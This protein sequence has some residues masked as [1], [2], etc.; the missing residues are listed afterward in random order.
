M[1]GKRIIQIALLGGAVVL[2]SSWLL[3]A[4]A[5]CSPEG[6]GIQ[7]TKAKPQSVCP[8]MGGKVDRKVFVDA[9]GYRVYLCCAGCAAKVK[10]DP[11][12]YIRKITANGETPEALCKCGNPMGAG[13]CK[14]ACAKAKAPT[15]LCKCGALKGSAACKLGCAAAKVKPASAAIDTPALATLVK[16]GVPLVVLDARS[17]KYDDGRRIPGAQALSAKADAKQAAA[18]IKSKD[19]LVVTYCSNL[20]CP[21]SRQL[22][23]R[24]KTLGYTNVLEYHK[25]IEGWAAAGLPVSSVKK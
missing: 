21:A 3:A 24:L 17:G 4:Q 15:A 20:K 12:K 7:I 2:L 1:N 22:A 16:S 14:A 10:A 25:G 5:G 23:Q 6:C 9:K 19:A 11:D 8:V 18:L 13:A